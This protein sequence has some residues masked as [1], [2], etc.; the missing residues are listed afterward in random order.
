MKALRRHGYAAEF[1]S[2]FLLVS[3]IRTCRRLSRKQALLYFFALLFYFYFSIFLCLFRV[4]LGFSFHCGLEVL[5]LF[6]QR[7]LPFSLSLVLAKDL[8][9]PMLCCIFKLRGTRASYPSTLF[10]C[11]YIKFFV[12]LLC[13]Y[14]YTRR[15]I[16][17]GPLF[18]EMGD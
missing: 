12:V 3:M 14:F 17:Y 8:L 16:M 4:K 18:G 2:F 15:L 13:L 11:Q 1:Y 10:L 5:L 9:I 7:C 6:F